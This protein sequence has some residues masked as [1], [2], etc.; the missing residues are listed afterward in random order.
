VAINQRRDRVTR[1]R[2]AVLG[3]LHLISATVA[4]R[5]DKAGEAHRH[6]DIAASIADTTGETNHFR[7]VFGPT[8]V[9]LHRVSAATE[10]GRTSEALDLAERTV[11]HDSPAVERRITFRLDAA[12]CFVRVKN[13]VAAVHM[14]QHVFHESP[15]EMRYSG[16]T[17]ESL[18]VLTARAKPAVRSDLQPMLVA[19]GLSD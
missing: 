4:A 17:R 5:D 9:Q 1:R 13:D 16:S 18:R 19:A 3:G 10:L 15:E 12:R 11:V 8:N 14:L 2:L 7:M 6:L